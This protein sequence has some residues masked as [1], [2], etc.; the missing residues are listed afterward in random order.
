M[1][2]K[3][4]AEAC[5]R[6]VRPKQIA[7]SSASHKAFASVADMPELGTSASRQPASLTGIAPVDSAAERK[8]LGRAIVAHKGPYMPAL[9]ATR[10]NRPLRAKSQLSG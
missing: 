6:V 3:A 7:R 4:C 1:V 10:V 5:L 8:E 2:L 9:V